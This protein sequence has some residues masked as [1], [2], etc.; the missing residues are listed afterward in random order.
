VNVT[1]DGREGAGPPRLERAGRPPAAPGAAYGLAAP[2]VT[3]AAAIAA[4]LPCQ[5]TLDA[6]GPLRLCYLAASSQAA[7]RLELCGG[8]GRF[9]LH[10]KR[11]TIEHATSDA[12][13]HDLGVTRRA[14]AVSRQVADAS[15][16]RD[17]FGGDLVA[18]LIALRS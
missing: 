11:G 13:E 5:G 6:T 14:G 10:F 12:P 9:A 18:A 2:E 16:V 4:G 3:P 7:G 17:G 8:S 15:R 1:D